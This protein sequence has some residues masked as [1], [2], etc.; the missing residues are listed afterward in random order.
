MAFSPHMMGGQAGH[1]GANMAG[2]MQMLSAPP[3]LMPPGMPMQPHHGG[4]QLACRGNLSSFPQPGH[5]AMVLGSSSL[6]AGHPSP[7]MPF[8][9]Q[10]LQAAR[11]QG[12]LPSIHSIGPSLQGYGQPDLGHTYG[13][14]GMLLQTPMSPAI[15]LS[16]A[17]RPPM[18]AQ[19]AQAMQDL[20]AMQHQQ[21]VAQS[22]GLAGGHSIPQTQNS[23]ISHP[24][25]HAIHGMP[26]PPQSPN[27]G[28]SAIGE[29]NSVF[30]PVMDSETSAPYD[31]KGRFRT[32]TFVYSC[33]CHRGTTYERR[34]PTSGLRRR[35]CVATSSWQW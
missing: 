35:K 20:R 18:Q 21:A 2:H 12:R 30:V 13:H 27:A 14:A 28:G 29:A 3:A 24:D 6:T 5:D 11:Q 26:A 16:P 17:G 22:M 15:N 1:P 31:I 34:W 10:Q 19:Q 9:M 33:L 7:M 8:E 23:A 25:L 32:D 4:M